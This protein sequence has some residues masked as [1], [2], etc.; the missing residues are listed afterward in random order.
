MSSAVMWCKMCMNQ[1]CDESICHAMTSRLFQINRT[2]GGISQIVGNRMWNQHSTLSMI[3]STEAACQWLDRGLLSSALWTYAKAYK[4][5]R[6]VQEKIIWNIMVLKV[7]F[8]LHCWYSPRV[9]T[10]ARHASPT[11]CARLLLLNSTRFFKKKHNHQNFREILGLIPPP[12]PLGGY[13]VHTLPIL[14]W[15]DKCG[16]SALPNLA[17]GSCL[18]NLQHHRYI[19]LHP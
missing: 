18:Q 6:M 9:N 15:K 3:I 16:M 4:A 13:E 1:W 12:P 10:C 2:S 5:L 8:R 19:R 17:L 14:A 7:L 11:L